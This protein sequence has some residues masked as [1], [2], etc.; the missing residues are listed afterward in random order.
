M[1]AGVLLVWWR[2][3]VNLINR[4]E[5]SPKTCDVE[6]IHCFI[7]PLHSFLSYAIK[8]RQ[9]LSYLIP[10][11]SS[12]DVV[13]RIGTRLLFSFF[14][15][16]SAR[17]CVWKE[18]IILCDLQREKIS[19][20]CKKSFVCVKNEEIQHRGMILRVDKQKRPLLRSRTT[21]A[22]YKWFCIR[23]A[24]SIDERRWE[25]K[26]LEDDAAK[27]GFFILGLHQDRSICIDHGLLEKSFAQGAQE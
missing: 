10:N 3:M 1:F 4:I 6:G 24:Q 13:Q 2:G 7:E 12:H 20:P 11:A 17:R 22:N 8:E 15:V 9:S 21:S 14:W 5:L 19:S 25:S 27:Y 18:K 16:W 26:S 23:C